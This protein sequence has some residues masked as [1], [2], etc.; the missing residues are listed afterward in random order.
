M[1]RFH[2]FVNRRCVLCGI[3]LGLL[4]LISIA[5]FD[6]YLVAGGLLTLFGVVML[7]LCFRQAKKEKKLPTANQASTE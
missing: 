7:Y 1:Q 4:G 2:D 5:I 3:I 6:S